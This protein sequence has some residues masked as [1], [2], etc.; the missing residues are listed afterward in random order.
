MISDIIKT[1]MPVNEKHKTSP[2]TA[3]QK[4]RTKKAITLLTVGGFYMF[5][6][7]MIV[8]CVVYRG[9]TMQTW[10]SIN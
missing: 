5:G 10:S 7:I 2:L 6:M 1:P 8:T 9:S 4:D 3:N